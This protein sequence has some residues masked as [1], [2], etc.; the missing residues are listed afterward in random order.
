MFPN[1]IGFP[2]RPKWDYS[3]SRQELERNETKMF[4]EWMD[5]V[6]NQYPAEELS[7]FEHNLEVWRQL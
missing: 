6:Y 4:E 3:M 1:V 7:Y 5:S 2:R